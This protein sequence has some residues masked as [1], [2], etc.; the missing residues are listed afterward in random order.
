M[1]Y[2]PPVPNLRLW[3][4]W[5]FRQDDVFHLFYLQREAHEIGCSAIGHATT[6]DWLHWETLPPVLAQGTGDQ[7]DA[8]PLMTGM[9]LAHAG[10]FYT[11]YGAMVDQVQRIGVAVS[12]DLLTWEKVGDAPV[13]EAQGRWYETEPQQALNYETAWRDP[14]VFYH[15]PESCF[16]AFICARVVDGG[17]TGGG[18]IAVAR[19]ENLV[20]WAL[21]PPAYVSDS[22]TCLE[23]P[24]YFQLDGRHYL[25][26]TTSYHFGTPYPVAH[27]Y[28]STGTFYLVSDTMLDGYHASGGP[29]ALNASLPDA[30]SSYVG[31]SI[32]HAADS[33]T[34]LY[35]YHNVYPPRLG[36]SWHGSL[37]MPKLLQAAPDGRLMLNY[38]ADLAERMVAHVATVEAPLATDRALNLV[39]ADLPDGMFEA[40]VTT[41][42]AGICFRAGTRRAGN[43]EGLA[44][45]L[46]PARKGSARWYVMLGTVHFTGGPQGARPALGI[47]SALRELERG[48]GRHAPP[49]VHLRVI[50]RGPFVDVYV[51]DVLYL[52]HTYAPEDAVQDAGGAGVFYAGAPK[53]RAVLRVAAH[54]LMAAD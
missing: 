31:R 23:V 39:A 16:Y 43:V 44:V 34:R 18:C 6:R 27:A 50:C 17:D 5:L 42:Y 22:M 29:Q 36:E 45:W 11:F 49:Q 4:T 37:S 38:A 7:W 25:T 10:R 20:D 2:T 12:D 28:Q 40:D 8:G 46:A 54:R 41:P 15:A 52:S 33:A 32:P 24:E 21:M 30:M 51:D 35:Y 13:L 26:F 48:I 9:T 19:S 47:P 14:Y 1:L 3:D 53:K